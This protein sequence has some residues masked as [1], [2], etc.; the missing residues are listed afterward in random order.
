MRP[1]S[2]IFVLDSVLKSSEKSFESKGQRVR[3]KGAIKSI[4]AKAGLSVYQES[5]VTVLHPNFN[6][7]V[8]WALY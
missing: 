4:F 6:P 3:T 7:V 8:V 2:F 1:F 5:K